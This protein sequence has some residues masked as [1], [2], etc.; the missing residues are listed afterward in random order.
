MKFGGN[1]VF[2][3]CLWLMLPFEAKAFTS[4]HMEWQGLKG[5]IQQLIE[6]E[7]DGGRKIKLI[8]G[9]LWQ[10]DQGDHL[11]LWSTRPFEESHHEV[12]RIYV[13]G[14]RGEREFEVVY[15]LSRYLEGA[16]ADR[17]VLRRFLGPAVRGWVAH[18]V[19]WLTG[20]WLNRQGPSFLRLTSF[21]EQLIERYSISIDLE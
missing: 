9:N 16:S 12:L 5:R 1:F 19:D 7:K 15:Y 14:S 4:L 20:E 3:L 6:A 2:G 18:T 21:E 17:P 13:P 8:A 10:V 11:V